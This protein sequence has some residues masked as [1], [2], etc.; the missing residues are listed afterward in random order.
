LA[1]LRPR[2]RWL[3]IG[4]LVLALAAAGVLKSALSHGTTVALPPTIG[5]PSVTIGHP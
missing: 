4:G 3:E 2:G 5:P 1:T